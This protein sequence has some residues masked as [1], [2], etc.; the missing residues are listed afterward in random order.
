MA[1]FTITFIVFLV[2]KMTIA[3]VEKSGRLIY[4]FQPTVHVVSWLHTL[5][6]GTKIMKIMKI[7]S[8]LHLQ[9]VVLTIL[10]SSSFLNGFCASKT[11]CSAWIQPTPFRMKCRLLKLSFKFCP[12]ALSG[13]PAKYPR[14]ANSLLFVNCQFVESFFH[15]LGDLWIMQIQ[16]VILGGGGILGWK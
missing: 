1:L 16:K 2:L 4:K 13:V 3:S 10:A 7:H 11:E 14:E 15:F 5:S 12:V 6:F 8:L 9:F